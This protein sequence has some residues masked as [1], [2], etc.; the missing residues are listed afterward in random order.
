MSAWKRQT[1][2][3]KIM[4]FVRTYLEITL[5]LVKLD[6]QEMVSAVMVMT[7]HFHLSLVA[8]D[9]LMFL[10]LDIDECE[11]GLDNCDSLNGECNNTDGS[12]ECYCRDGYLF[13]GTYCESMC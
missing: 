6:I 4:A 7:F 5:V 8:S 11:D 9:S 3:T 12:F 1:T 13:N 2:V 10:I